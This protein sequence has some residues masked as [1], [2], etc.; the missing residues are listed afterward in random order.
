MKNFPAALFKKAH[1]K[2]FVKDP[3]ALCA[4]NLATIVT[5]NKNCSA[6][7]QVRHDEF[8]LI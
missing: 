1:Q 2:F 8:N 3:P 7:E 4:F 5:G 6:S